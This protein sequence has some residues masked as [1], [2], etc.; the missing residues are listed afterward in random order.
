MIDVFFLEESISVLSDANFVKKSPPPPQKKWDW[1]R[2]A[3]KPKDKIFF[4]L[5][6]TPVMPARERGHMERKGISYSPKRGINASGVRLTPA[7]NLAHS[8]ML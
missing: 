2:N 7:N 5:K 3:R 6:K 1:G 4:F 8:E